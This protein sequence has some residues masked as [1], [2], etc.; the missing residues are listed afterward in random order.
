MIPKRDNVYNIKTYKNQPDDPMNNIID[1]I[2]KISKYDTL[3]IV[4]PLKPV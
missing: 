1:S 4:M 2:G 3:T